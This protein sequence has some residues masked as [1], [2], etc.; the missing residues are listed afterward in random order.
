MYETIYSYVNPECVVGFFF[1]GVVMRV[2]HGVSVKCFKF[3]HR[4]KMF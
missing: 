1:G 2:C 4:V 3:D